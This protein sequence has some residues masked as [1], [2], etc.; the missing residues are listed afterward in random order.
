MLERSSFAKPNSAPPSQP[1]DRLDEDNIHIALVDDDDDFREVVGAELGDYGFAVTD[2]QDGPFLLDY[3]G[4]GNSADVIIL[5]WNLPTL[6][7]IDLLAQLRRQGV[8]IPVIILTALSGTAYEMAA[9]DRGALD[10]IDKSRGIPVLAKRARLIAEAAKLPPDMPTEEVIEYG[11]LKLRPRLSRAYWQDVDVGLTVTEFNIVR[12][13]IEHAGDHV[14]YRAIY[15]CVH[16]CGFIAGSG[17]DGY[18]TNVR[19]SVKRIRNKFRAI[20]AGFVEIENFPA[21]GYCWKP[22]ASVPS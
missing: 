4:A 9:L 21:F 11:P 14:S 15:D 12:R 1:N 8:K 6:P 2:F 20:D 22:A 16:H 17:E 7:G 18:R 5:D 10:F 3:F 13:L 19:S